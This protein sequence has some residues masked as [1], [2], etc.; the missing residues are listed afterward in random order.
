MMFKI[1]VGRNETSA[2]TSASAPVMAGRFFSSG[3]NGRTTNPHGNKRGR[4][5]AFAPTNNAAARPDSHRSF[6]ERDFQARQPKST[7]A[8]AYTV[9]KVSFPA[10]PAW[11]KKL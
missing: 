10:L 1:A 7:A 9:G 5:L 6:S 11:S 3:T 2:A 4:L 8:S